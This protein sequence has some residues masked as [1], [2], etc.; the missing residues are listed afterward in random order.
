MK[1]LV[2]RSSSEPSCLEPDEAYLFRVAGGYQSMY[3]DHG[4]EAEALV[5][6]A[7]VSYAF[8]KE[9]AHEWIEG[10]GRSNLRGWREFH[11][12]CR[13]LS[14]PVAADTAVEE[15]LEIQDR[16]ERGKPFKQMLRSFR[17]KFKTQRRTLTPRQRG[18]YRFVKTAAP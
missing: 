17:A 11:R 16:M 14:L 2:L 7:G 13:S 6:T 1:L 12:V 15:L 3:G 8:R 4:E 9:E 18:H 10:K 5:C